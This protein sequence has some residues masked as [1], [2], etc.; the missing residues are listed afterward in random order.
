MPTPATA[1]SR[2][3]TRAGSTGLDI[4]RQAAEAT[5]GRIRVARSPLGGARLTLELPVILED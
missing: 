1:L 3:A 4:A 5:G 2:G